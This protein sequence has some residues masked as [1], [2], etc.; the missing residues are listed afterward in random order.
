M[1]DQRDFK[2]ELHELIDRTEPKV[3]SGDPWVEG[4]RQDVGELV[5]KHRI[6]LDVGKYG[7][8]LT[9]LMAALNVGRAHKLVDVLEDHEASRGL[10]HLTNVGIQLFRLGGLVLV[11]LAVLWVVGLL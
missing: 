4:F 7:G 6:S 5:K 2:R 3:R 8:Q 10:L 1:I 11:I 9:K